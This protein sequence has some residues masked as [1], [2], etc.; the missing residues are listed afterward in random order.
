MPRQKLE[1]SASYRIQALVLA[2]SYASKVMEMCAGLCIIIIMTVLFP[3]LSSSYCH[4]T[5]QVNRV[6]LDVYMYRMLILIRLCREQ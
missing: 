6:P 2:V 3:C 4:V 5:L 1:K